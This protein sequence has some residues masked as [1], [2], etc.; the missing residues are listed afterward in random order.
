ML[1]PFFSFYG[2]KWRAAPYYPTP[3][4]NRVIEPFAGA[5]GYSTRHHE[6]DVVLVEADPVIAGLWRW[7]IAAPSSEV[8][9]LPA[10]V[11]VVS[12]G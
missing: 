11:S 3:Q 1:R 2:G 9:A 8:L 7:L 10:V 12:S 6:R 5:A 4:F